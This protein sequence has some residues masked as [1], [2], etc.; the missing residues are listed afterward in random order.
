M[1]LRAPTLRALT[2]AAAAVGLAV[3]LAPPVAAAPETT[4][5][6]F[7]NCDKLKKGSPEWKKCTAKHR[8]DMTDQELFH[9]GY[10]LAH[11]GQYAE[12]LGYLN[13]AKA[14]DHR[15][16]TYIGFATRKLGDHDTAL[17]YYAKALALAPDYT[18]ARAYLGEAHIARGNVAEARVQLAEIGTRCGTTCPEYVE[19]KTAITQT[20]G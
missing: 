11:T 12:A 7:K 13:R 15:I 1:T 4:V 8:E 5:P 9:V 19:L 16:L 3:A 6:D 2:L 20:G 17:G 18:V 14:P 10:W